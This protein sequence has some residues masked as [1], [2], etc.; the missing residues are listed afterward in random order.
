MDSSQFKP[1]DMDARHVKPPDILSSSLNPN[2]GFAGVNE[3]TDTT[4]SSTPGTAPIRGIGLRVTNI[5]G[6][7]LM[8]R[9]GLYSTNNQSVL[10]GLEAIS[11]PVDNLFAAGGSS[12]MANK[13]KPDSVHDDCYWDTYKAEESVSYAE[14]VQSTRMKREVNFRLMKPTES[15]DDADVV[16]PREVV[17]KVQNKFDNVL[18]GYFLGNRL[19]FPVVEY[20]A[21]NVWAK[22][23]FSKLMMNTSGFFFFKF[24]S[25]EGLTKVLEG[26]PW[27]IRKVPL[28]LNVWSPKVTLKKDSIKTVPVWVKLHNVPIAVY[29]DDGLSLLAS[30][31]GTPKRLDS[32]TADMCVDNWGRSSYARAMIE[33]NADN[34]LKDYITVAIPKMDEEGFVLERVKV[35]YEWKPL[36]CSSCCLFGHDDNT[37][38]KKPKGK[39][40]VVTVDEEGF[41][42][43][44]RRMARYSF[45]QKKQKPRVVYK[46][47]TNKNHASTSETKG[48][49]SDVPLSNAFEVLDNSKNEEKRDPTSAKS[50]VDET[51]GTRIQQPEEVIEVIPTEMAD[52]MRDKICKK[53]FRNWSWTSNGGVCDRGTRVILG[54]NADD[55]DLMVVS[56]SDQDRRSLW[57][58][59]CNFRGITNDVPWVVMGDFNAALNM[60]DFLTGPS[61]HTI[62]MRDFYDCVQNTELIDVKSHGL[63]FTWSQRP[64]DGV[65]TLK[66]IDRIM[67]NVKLLDVFPDAYAMFQPFRV[68]DHAPGMLRLASMDTGRPKPFK[69]PNFITSK[70]DFG[71]AVTAEWS[72]NV[73]GVAMYSVV[74]KM[75]SLKPHFRRILRN[76]G[77]LHKRVTELRNQLD[78]IQKQVDASP[79]DTALRSSEAICLQE[80][81]IAAYDEECFLKQKAKVQ[82]L[83]AGDSNTSYFHN[84]VKG[85]N[86]R[87][88]IHCIKDTKGNLFEGDD[89]PTALLAHYSVFMGTED[90]VDKVD[91]TDM[92]VNVLQPNVAENMV[93]QVTED[94]VKR[95]MFSIGEN[96]APGPDGYTSAFF[97]KSWDVVGGEVTKAVLDFF[98]NGQILKQIN[99]TILALVP[100]VE[101]PNTVLDYRPISCCNVLYKCI[102]KIITDRIKR[103]LGYL[104]NINQSAFV[105]GRKISDN[106]LLTQE[107]MHNYHVDRGPPR[108]ALKIDIQKAYDTV[109]WSFLEEILIRF[110]FHQKMISWIMAC[111]TTVSYSVSINGELHGYFRG[112]RGLRQGDPMSPYLFTL[113]MEVLSLMLQKMALNNAFRFHLHCSK[114]KIINVSFADDLFVFV[115][116]DM[117]SVQLIQSVLGKFTSVSGLVPS[118]PK[119]T[120]FFCNVPSDVKSNILSLLPFREG[121][122]PVR[123]LGVPLIST[124]LSFRDCRI[125]VERMERKVDN[126]LTKSLSFAGR[127]QLIKS[128]LSAMYTYWASV[129]ILPMRIVK[130]LEKRMRRFLWNASS[131]RS[132]RS[133]VPWKDVCK[134]KEEGG[135]GIRSISEVNKAL[136]TSHIWSIITNRESLW[137]QW[138]HA[139][140]LKGRN[141]WEI[142]ARGNLTWSWRKILAI[143]SLV[144]PFV[145]KS[146]GNGNGT[147]VWSDNWCSC[148]P[149]RHF[150]T[151]RMI[152]REGFTLT[153]T[154]ADIIDSNGD[155]R[156]P[157]AWLDL[158]PVLINVA[159]PVIAQDME[160]RFGW[161]SFDGK[162]G[163]FTS[164]EAWNNLRVRENKVAWVNMVWY[165]QCIPRHSF[166]IWLVITNKLKTQDRLAVWEAGSETNLIL[167]CCPLCKYGRDSRDHLFFQC[168]FSAKVWNIVNKR[169]DMGM[170][171]DTWSSVMAWVDQHANS[172]KL[173]H[174]VCKLVVAASTYFIWQ[175]RNNRLFSNLQR[176]ENTVAQ[177]ILDIVRL[178]IMGFKVSGDVNH[179][180]LL[181]RWKIKEDDPG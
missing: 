107:L 141:F 130:D 60:E 163:H 113:V 178:R 38:H 47:K 71:Q 81:K 95:A 170:V 118:L 176:S 84:Y 49:T 59:L 31:L 136:I 43:D 45:P 24:D 19:P 108:C 159:R 164:C 123:Y 156:W 61:S 150:I 162:I 1:S 139:Y 117:G 93:R 109:S 114:Q 161:K 66:K 50:M 87:S 165:G 34:E 76:Q 35:E 82:W 7:T 124:R 171:N 78:Q 149:I 103:G 18:Y 106:I 89:V 172:K 6:N 128:V 92:F 52:F 46:P 21:K 57:T 25:K 104:V 70:P 97:K 15:R 121:S 177:L 129:F 85:R 42:T 168:C 175:E 160:D 127:L 41:V 174:I 72:K 100:K 169:V 181:E 3:N 88:K 51:H 101:T 179:R 151:P 27:L 2:K 20:Y 110:G 63:H 11:I 86:A 146:I 12:S 32:Y 154:V 29:T 53:V 153:N 90:Q 152:A 10:D 145:W 122:L 158:F 143:R 116:G 120:I 14:K 125:L 173:E 134:P 36:R 135:L 79:F 166:H 48:D 73:E 33:I 80:Y 140:R 105:P 30:K 98:S 131:S 180:K 23:G 44:N 40:K 133:K 69:F 99:H 28:F 65:G 8:P 22:Y 58:D 137:V 62:A 13:G 144:R 55:I 75:K 54:W 157:Q 67:G 94:E 17:Q 142:P 83:C 56:Q 132:T 91:D 102:S 68:S 77:N 96:K 112:K 138:I 126:W 39:A 167:M 16:I 74:Q 26:G 111:V 147:N 155:W 64:K 37:C 115:N 9:R 5:E 148:S 4:P 119:S